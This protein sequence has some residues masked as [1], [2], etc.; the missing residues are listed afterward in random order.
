MRC[1]G[2]DGKCN[3]MAVAQWRC[4]GKEPWETCEDCQEEEFGG[5]P[6][7]FEFDE[8]VA[9]VFF[10]FVA[11][12]GAVDLMEGLDFP[13]SFQKL[14]YVDDSRLFGVETRDV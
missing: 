3:Q 5:W 12:V 11:F 4:E 1:M 14:F 2:K 13:Y 8:P 9:Q 10:V 7:G 6:E